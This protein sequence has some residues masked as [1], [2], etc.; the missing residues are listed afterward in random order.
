MSSFSQN[1]ARAT[2]PLGGEVAWNE[3]THLAIGAHP[4]DLEFMAG[5]GIVQCEEPNAK[6]RGFG[7]VTVAAGAEDATM[8]QVR[9]LEQEAAAKLGGY[10]AIVTLD[11]LSRALKLGDRTS[12]VE[13]LKTILRQVK[14]EVLYTHN[15]MD[16]HDTHV[17][18]CLS[19]IEALRALPPEKH[20]KVVYGCEVWRGLDWLMDNDK[21]P[22]DVS[23]GEP[24]LRKLMAVYKSQLVDKA[25]DEAVLGRKRSNATFLD[26]RASDQMK[27]CEYAVDMTPLIR[28]PKLSVETWVHS[29]IKDF[30]SDVMGRL[31][32]FT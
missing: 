12:L 15:P 3:I 32:R 5:H 19:V 11:H 31:K 1:G 26:A 13:D 24:L 30:E 6:S 8:K 25:Y 18:V 22:L 9:R 14:L 21:I 16:K 23:N 28:D 2:S 29:H 10:K 7:G 17:A 27:L 20:P 4:D